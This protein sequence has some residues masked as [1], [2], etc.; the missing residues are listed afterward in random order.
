MS[1]LLQTIITV[2]I[3][4]IAV[5]SLVW[6]A[7]FKKKKSCCNTDCSSCTPCSTP[8]STPCAQYKDNSD[9]NKEDC[10]SNKSE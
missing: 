3:C 9:E 8:C 1:N 4:L 6:Y 10:G 5:A 7:F 2:V